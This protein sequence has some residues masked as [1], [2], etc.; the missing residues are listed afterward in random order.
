MRKPIALLVLFLLV[1]ATGCYRAVIETARPPG[2]QTIDIPWAH[3]FVY[4]IVPPAV[5]NSA[6]QCPSGVARVVTEH[7]FLN[8]LVAAIT[9]GIYTPV[10]IT[11]TCASGSASLD[12]PT[13]RTLAEAEA[14]LENGEAFLLRLREETRTSFE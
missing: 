13:V 4:G 3:S 5:V 12:L 2:T 1:G 8:G 6:T 9:W 7:S 10:H 14:R 11:V